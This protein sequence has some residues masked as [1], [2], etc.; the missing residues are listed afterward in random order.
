MAES[1]AHVLRLV[2]ALKRG[3]KDAYR[4]LVRS[5]GESLHRYAV[6]IT[7][8]HDLA[9]DVVQDAFLKIYKQRA[10]LDEHAEFRGLC[11]Q[12]VRNLARNAVRDESLRKRREQEAAEMRSGEDHSARSEGKAAWELV[13]KL[14]NALREVLE[15]R[16]SFG[17]NRSE[18]AEALQ[19]PEGTVATRQRKGLEELRGKLSAVAPALPLPKLAAL[20]ADVTPSSPVPDLM[21]M[22]ELVM[23]GI[24]SM[25]LKMAGMV[26][27]VSLVIL[28]LLGGGAVA[29]AVSNSDMQ[30][31]TTVASTVDE[32]RQPGIQTGRQ[33]DNAAIPMPDPAQELPEPKPQPRPESQPEPQPEPEPE[34]ESHPAIDPKPQPA[35]QPEPQPLPQPLPEL[36]PEPQPAN[37]APEFR[38]EPGLSATA[39]QEYSYRIDVI[40][41]PAPRIKASELPAWLS[42]RDNLLIGTPASENGGAQ[43]VVLIADNGVRPQAEQRFQLFVSTAPEFESTPPNE[44]VAGTEYVYEIEL[45]AEPD[46]E[47]S[48]EDAPAW[49]KLSG[50]TLKGTPAKTDVGTSKPVKLKASNGVNPDARQTFTIKVKPAPLGSGPLDLPWSGEEIS[51]YMMKDLRWSFGRTQRSKQRDGKWKDNGF[52][53]ADCHVTDN[54]NGKLTVKTIGYETDKNYRAKQSGDKDE[55]EWEK[56]DLPHMSMLYQLGFATE[57]RLSVMEKQAWTDDTITLEGEEHAAWKTTLKAGEGNRGVVGGNWSTKTPVDRVHW[58]IKDKPEVTLDI[59]GESYLC[60]RWTWITEGLRGDSQKRREVFHIWV[61]KNRPGL[62]AKA[63]QTWYGGA[64]LDEEEW[65]FE[66]KLLELK[67]PRALQKKLEK[68]DKKD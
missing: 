54:S 25:Q 52:T 2:P 68:Q 23:N 20:L 66:C 44:A 39:G 58:V 51:E 4:E 40:G 34:P 36:E 61:I 17:L 18:T 43:T 8:D 47:L 13:S 24:R 50:S 31:Q 53:R 45:K 5:M 15:L 21:M 3:G 33:P 65:V 55:S 42:L 35:V 67:E 27:S 16:F 6:S 48:V 28:L 37:L 41:V 56:E 22:E 46:A 32:S 29:Y 11:F 10:T 12:I 63:T 59:D 26:A 9:S 62:I 64:A 57:A 60:E 14:P 49:L 7:R 1:F 38:S 30:T 19:I